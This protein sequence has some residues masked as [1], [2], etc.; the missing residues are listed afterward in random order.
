MEILII[1]FLILL[2]GVFSMSEIALVSARKNRLTNAAQHGH[3][4]AKTALELQAA[5]S[6]LL[7]TVQIGITL[8][9]LMTGI[10]SGEKITNDMEAF[11]SQFPALAPYA[12]TLGVAVV[13]IIITFFSLVLGELVPKRIGL[14]YPETIARTMAMPMKIIATITA[15]FIWLLTFTTDL[16][17]K[18][19]GVKRSSDSKVTEEEIKAIVREGMEDGEIQEIEQNIVNRVFSV[20]DR[21]VSSLMTSRKM[22]TTLDILDTRE[23]VK[24]LVS[25]DLHNFYPI[26]D[27]EEQDIVGIVSLKQ[28]FAEIEKEEF[29]LKR[30]ITEPSYIAESASAYKAL[31]QFKQ[32]NIHYALVIDEYGSTQGILTMSD[33][34]EALVGDISEFYGE[35]YLFQQRD[36]KSWLI[37]GHYPLPDFLTRFGMEDYIKDYEVNTVGGLIMHVLG[38]IPKQ[39]EKIEWVNFEFEVMD[40]DGPTIDKI[41]ITRK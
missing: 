12:S 30:I 9:G 38:R 31:E 1:L 24:K 8:I 23:E 21:S 10:Y 35:E 29:D 28:L 13:L 18:L 14:T 26:Y 22:M 39:S 20:G 5:P 32:T 17:L 40:M 6:K 2:N 37:D 11:I 27:S 4:G 34:L 15:P 3:K 33:I 25:E 16:L 19:F 36:E 7:S 41:L